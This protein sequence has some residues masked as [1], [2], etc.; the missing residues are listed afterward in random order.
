MWGSDWKS[1]FQWL[2][3]SVC[4][5][6]QATVLSILSADVCLRLVKLRKIKRHWKIK[7]VMLSALLSEEGMEA[8]PT[9]GNYRKRMNNRRLWY[10]L[11][12]LWSSLKCHILTFS[13]I[14]PCIYFLPSSGNR[15]RVV[16]TSHSLALQA[17]PKRPWGI[18]SKQR[19]HNVDPQT[20]LI[21]SWQF[22]PFASA[23]S[24]VCSLP[25]G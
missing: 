2:S 20:T 4:R 22:L 3:A 10:A 7:E 12:Y 13:L 16:Q 24:F 18:P 17:L 14:H 19:Q 15:S 11:L 8:L 1:K 5:N 9:I 25:T 23:V 6:Q 21:G